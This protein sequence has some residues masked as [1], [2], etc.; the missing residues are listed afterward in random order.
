MGQI[1]HSADSL[2][3]VNREFCSIGKPS[4]LDAVPGS[5][6][7]KQLYLLRSPATQACWGNGTW[8]HGAIVQFALGKPFQA[9]SGIQFGTA[10][11][12]Q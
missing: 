7:L 2:L 10:A 1:Q 8:K 11:L 3:C 12:E 4:Y 6:T 5:P 9:L